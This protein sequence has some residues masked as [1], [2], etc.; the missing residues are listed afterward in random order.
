M[1]YDANGRL[2]TRIDPNGL[3]TQ[4][5]YDPLRRVVSLHLR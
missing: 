3:T 4:F 2:L 5:A 1:A